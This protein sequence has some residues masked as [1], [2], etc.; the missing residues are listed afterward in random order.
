ML[1]MHN[2]R[3]LVI[4]TSLTA[5]APA[6]AVTDDDLAQIRQSIEQLKSQHAEDAKRIKEL[7]TNSARFSQTQL[8]IETPF[9]N[10]SILE[11]VLRTCSPKTRLCIACNLT[12][13]DE[14]IKT[15]TITDWK[16]NIPDLHKKPT[17]F[18]LA[19]S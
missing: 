3:K 17:I 12:G 5:V 9:R 16:K 15:Q 14:F 4:V 10:N 13:E 2:L 1:N 7:E 8:F 19:G 18:L 6:F 11:E